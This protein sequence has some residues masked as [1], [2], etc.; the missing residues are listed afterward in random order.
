M[1]KIFFS[2]MS[3]CSPQGELVVGKDTVVLRVQIK[4]LFMSSPVATDDLGKYPDPL[5][6]SFV[7]ACI[8][9]H[10]ASIGVE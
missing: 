7:W 3:A 8:E 4:W 6:T 1:F 2:P 5:Q 10:K 9:I